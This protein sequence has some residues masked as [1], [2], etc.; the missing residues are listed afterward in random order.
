[1]AETRTIEGRTWTQGDGPFRLK[2]S[3]QRRA[4]D[5]RAEGYYA[6]VIRERDWYDGRMRY[7][8]YVR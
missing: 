6:R 1:M 8:I 2:R 5:F 3:A 7:F 4:D